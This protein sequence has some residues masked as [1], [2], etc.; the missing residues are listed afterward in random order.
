MLMGLSR[1]KVF[2]VKR[3]A[4]RRVVALNEPIKCLHKSA[5][6]K[7]VTRGCGHTGAES[8]PEGP[9]N[10]GRRGLCM[11]ACWVCEPREPGSEEGGPLGKGG[12]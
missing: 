9:S 1:G 3:G 8:F 11:M 10:E 2:N 12:I 4:R 5:I 7:N 6:A